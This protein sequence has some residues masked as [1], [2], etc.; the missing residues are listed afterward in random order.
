MGRKKAQDKVLENAEQEIDMSPIEDEEQYQYDDEGFSSSLQI[1]GDIHKLSPIFD[2]MPHIPKEVKYAFYDKADLWTMRFKSGVYWDY[3]YFKKLIV[4]SEEEMRL[5]YK[6]RREFYQIKNDT[7][8]KEYLKKVNKQYLYDSLDQLDITE[9][10]QAMRQ[11]FEQI[12]ESNEMGI[13]DTL[14]DEKK[15]FNDS[16]EKYKKEFGANP[17][18][19]SLGIL[20]NMLMITESSKGYKGQE[21]KSINTTISESKNIDEIKDNAEDTSDESVSGFQKL[22]EKFSKK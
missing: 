3:K 6:L 16:F 19:D 8:L 13:V 14:Y 4:L 18:I 1:G 20:N 21:R 11:I 10:K 5:M 22:K 12:E 17:S 2:E 9:R 15:M 7:Q